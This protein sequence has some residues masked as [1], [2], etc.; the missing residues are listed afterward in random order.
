M[1]EGGVHAMKDGLLLAQ[2][3]GKIAKAKA[4]EAVMKELFAEYQTE[5]LERGCRAVRMSRAQLGRVETGS[6]SRL[7]WGHAFK[8]LPEEHISLGNIPFAA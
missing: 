7:S 2:A 3:I 5:M 4:D 6:N 8:V 1:G